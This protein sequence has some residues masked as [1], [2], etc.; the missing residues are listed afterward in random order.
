MPAVKE[1]WSTNEAL[2]GLQLTNE[3]VARGCHQVDIG[4]AMY[5]Q[6]PLWVEKLQKV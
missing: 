5:E 4:D 3:L 2:T 1:A 6:D